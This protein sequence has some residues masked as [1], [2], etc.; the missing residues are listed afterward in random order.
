MYIIRIQKR[1]YA[2]VLFSASQIHQ[3]RR[4]IFAKLLDTAFYS[5]QSI[6]LLGLLECAVM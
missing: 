1:G 2:L 4:G 3:H 5:I 6:R